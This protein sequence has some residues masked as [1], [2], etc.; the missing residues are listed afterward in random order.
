MP[1]QVALIGHSQLPWIEDYEDVRFSLFKRGGAQI[2]DIYDSNR[3]DTESIFHSNWDCVFLF[4]GGN[5]LCTHHNAARVVDDLLSLVDKIQAEAKFITAIEPR[6][7]YPHNAERYNITT[8]DYNRMRRIANTKLKTIARQWKE[9][10][11]IN[12]PPSY[13]EDSP[14]GIHFCNEARAL[15]IQKYWTAIGHARGN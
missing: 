1:Y 4:L 14:D 7:Y 9:F 8:E 5:D 3:F 11:T 10:R 2:A 12:C 15:L 13:N 6:T